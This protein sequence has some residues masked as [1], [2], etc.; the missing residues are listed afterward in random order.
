MGGEQGRKEAERPIDTTPEVEGLRPR[1]RHRPSQCPTSLPGSQDP[2][3][4]QTSLS[5]GGPKAQAR[6]GKKWGGAATVRLD[7][8]LVTFIQHLLWLLLPFVAS[9]TREK[10]APKGGKGRRRRERLEWIQ[11]NSEESQF[12]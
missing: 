12:V 2:G 3:V 11:I 10:V 1:R 6:K 9:C 7:V 8:K 5:G 4:R